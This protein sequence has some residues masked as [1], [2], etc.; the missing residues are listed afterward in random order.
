MSENKNIFIILISCV[1]VIDI[2][3]ICL[4]L[5]FVQNLFKAYIIVI[6]VILLSIA[7]FLMVI[8]WRQPQN[9]NI[10]TFKVNFIKK[11]IYIAVLLVNFF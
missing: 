3:A 9:V 2:L 6:L 5:T 8:V 4:I 7:I 11:K 1:I 10:K